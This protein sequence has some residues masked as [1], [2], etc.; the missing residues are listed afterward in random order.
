MNKTF[1]KRQNEY[2]EVHIKGDGNCFFSAIVLALKTHVH[3]EACKKLQNN[4]SVSML[5]YCLAESVKNLPSTANEWA[6]WKSCVEVPEMRQEFAFAVP[7][8]HSAKNLDDL[9][10]NIKIQVAQNMMDKS[11]YWGDQTAITMLSDYLNLNICVLDMT[12]ESI[13]YTLH[14]H[15]TQNGSTDEQVIILVHR[16]PPAHYTIVVQN[17]YDTRTSAFLFDKENVGNI[18]EH[19]FAANNNNNNNSNNNNYHSKNKNNNNKCNC[20]NCHCEREWHK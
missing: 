5:R 19:F 8:L 20:Q 17:N 14:N 15:P 7:L 6:I 4:I 11:K 10:D 13:V 12:N 3:H 9:T 2:K 16:T 1:T 18:A